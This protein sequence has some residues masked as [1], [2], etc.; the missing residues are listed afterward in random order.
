M[1]ISYSEE[2]PQLDAVGSVKADIVKKKS[3]VEIHDQD[4][5]LVTTLDYPFDEKK[6]KREI[7]KSIESLKKRIEN[8]KNTIGWSR[9]RPDLVEKEKRTMTRDTQLLSDLLEFNK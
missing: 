3:T 5:Q 9:D 2:I 1:I 7:R 4:D 6:V 8:S